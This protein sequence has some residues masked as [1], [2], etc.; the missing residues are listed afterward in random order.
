MPV[1]PGLQVIGT[2]RGLQFASVML[3]WSMKFMLALISRTA[4]IIGLTIGTG[5]A[6]KSS[7]LGDCNRVTSQNVQ[8]EP[9][10]VT[11]PGGVHSFGVDAVVVPDVSEK[12][13][14]I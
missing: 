10:S 5:S 13:Q 3:G 8:R 6:C 9:G 14:R 12:I 4:A 1:L 2:V 11:L 7:E